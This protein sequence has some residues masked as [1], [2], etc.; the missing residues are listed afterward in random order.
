MCLGYRLGTGCQKT[1][2][3]SQNRKHWDDYQL[4]Y[5]CGNSNLTISYRKQKDIEKLLLL[6]QIPIIH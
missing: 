6:K 1:V 3:A 4:C 5:N 2:K